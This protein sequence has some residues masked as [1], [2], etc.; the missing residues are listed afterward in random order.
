MSKNASGACKIGTLY[1]YCKEAGIDVYSEKTKHIIN[2]VKIAK[3]Q[4]NPTVESIER[5]LAVANDII[6]DENDR[7][8]IQELIDSKIDYS[9]EANDDKSETEQLEDFILQTYDPYIDVITNI[10]YINGG[11]HLT[12]TVLLTCKH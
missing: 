6:T 12:C 2:R 8:L 5:N 1:Y 9:K 3:N 7:K 10:T 11:T 4:G